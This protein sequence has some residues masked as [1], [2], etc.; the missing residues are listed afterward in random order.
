MKRLIIL[1]LVIVVLSLIV[2]PSISCTKTTTTTATATTTATKTSS[3]QVTTSTAEPIKVI[4]NTPDGRGGTWEEFLNAYLGEIEQKAGGKLK[5]EVHWNGELAGMPDCYDAAFKGTVN[6]SVFSVTDP[7]GRF[8]MDEVGAISHWGAVNYGRAR[9]YYELHQKFPEMDKAFEGTKIIFYGN[10]YP[11]YTFTTKKAGPITKLEDCNGLKIVGI[12]T[13]QGDRYKALGMV[14][15]SIDPGDV[16][17]SLEKGIADVMSCAS[18]LTVDFGWGEVLPYGTFTEGPCGQMSIAVNA[19]FWNNLPAD[20]QK[21][22][23]DVQP[24]YEE[25]W[26]HLMINTDQKKL[27]DYKAKFNGQI[28]TLSKEEIAR[29]QATEKPIYDKYVAAVNAE[30]LPGQALVDEFQRLEQKYS[31]PQYAPK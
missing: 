7:P 10:T 8:I 19:K 12:G 26:D 24:K 27:A 13:W 6:A 22:I 20:I 16:I 1:C 31:D 21:I 14:P 17:P 11:Y 18:F 5:F 3:T 29:W 25:Y 4:F 2:V 15:L 28:T 23:L 9:I 30:G